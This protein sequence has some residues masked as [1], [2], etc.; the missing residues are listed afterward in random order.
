MVIYS[1]KK[2]RG[3]RI[4]WTPYQSNGN[5]HRTR[6]KSFKIIQLVRQAYSGAR[7]YKDFI[8]LVE[9]YFLS[10][11]TSLVRRNMKF[12]CEV[13]RILDIN[14]EVIPSSQFAFG[15][16]SNDLLIDLVR[17]VDGSVYL[18]GQGA[19]SYQDDSR[20]IEWYSCRV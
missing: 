16:R 4:D 12:I 20:F 1:S 6:E 3:K 5:K 10:E 19:G 17:A 15:S 13:L 14:T 18:C 9:D 7:Y 11:D 8:Y 2:A